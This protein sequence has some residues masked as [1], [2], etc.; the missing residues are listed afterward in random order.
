MT[1]IE[2]KKM[3]PSMIKCSILVC[4]ARDSKSSR[5]SKN[6]YALSYYHLLAMLCLC[7]VTSVISDSQRLCGWEPTVL[8]SPW[9]FPGMNA[10]VSCH[11]LL[12][13]IFPTLEC[14]PH[15]FFLLHWQV[16]SLSLVPPGK[17]PGEVLVAQL[18]ST[19][20][21]PWIV[22]HQDPQSTEFSRQ[23]YWSGSHSLLQGIF[24]TQRSNP[25]MLR[26]RQII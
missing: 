8:L 3:H 1:V 12:Q 26:C 21:S 2:I 23:E 9:D 14:N 4:V 17:L 10:V 22:A 13:G 15:F 6:P 25:G 18:C 7:A 19:L 20:C 11:A 16:G 5:K 24:L